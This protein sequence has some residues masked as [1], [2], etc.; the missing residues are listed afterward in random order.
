MLIIN[1]LPTLKDAQ[2]MPEQL[3]LLLVQMGHPPADIRAAV[4]DVVNYH[5]KGLR[6]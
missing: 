5:P 3:P 2:A 4:G 6:S 1:L